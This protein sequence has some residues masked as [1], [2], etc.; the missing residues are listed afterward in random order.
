M[1]IV[2]Q[3]WARELIRERLGTYC[4]A[5][6]TKNWDLL[7]SCFG[8][9]HV[10]KHGS[11]QGDADGFVEFVRSKFASLEMSQHALSN[12]SIVIAPDGLRANSEANFSSVHRFG[13]DEE[14]EAYDW[15]VEGTY[16][17][18]LICS[19]GVWL[20]VNRVGNSRWQRRVPV[21]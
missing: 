12:I 2:E 1:D 3:L 15:F 19:N 7:R 6:D 21:T 5:V 4:K 9:G 16:S 13:A 14:N 8:E 10:H 11:Y 20:I 17:D 18:E